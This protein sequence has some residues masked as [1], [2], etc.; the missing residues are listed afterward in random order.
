MPRL[1]LHEATVE[2][3][4]NGR[5]EARP[6]GERSLESMYDPGHFKFGCNDQAQRVQRSQWKPDD[7]DCSR[8][9]E[10]DPLTARFGGLFAD[11]ENPVKFRFIAESIAQTIESALDSVV[12]V[13]PNLQ[14][15]KGADTSSTASSVGRL[16]NPLNIAAIPSL[17]GIIGLFNSINWSSAVATRRFLLTESANWYNLP[18]PTAADDRR[19]RPNHTKPWLTPCLEASGEARVCNPPLHKVGHRRPPCSSDG[20]KYGEVQWGYYPWVRRAAGSLTAV[21]YARDLGI[22]VTAASVH[23]EARVVWV[24]PLPQHCS[25]ECSRALARRP[26]MGQNTSCSPW[27]YLGTQL[28]VNGTHWLGMN[29]ISVS[30][31]ARQ[32]VCPHL[33]SGTQSLDG[34]EANISR[35]RYQ[36]SERVLRDSNIPVVPLE[37]ALSPKWEMHT[38]CTHWVRAN[39]NPH[40][41]GHPTHTQIDSR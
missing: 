38:D 3:L 31:A 23:S 21:D 37:T 41:R 19:A 4:R 33:D 8:L 1:T 12:K 34:C 24:E 16:S 22:L 9:L 28:G 36:V 39:R 13:N 10:L 5:W 2:C 30:P 25:A 40:R 11:P 29:E 26:R 7:P 17:D 27:P 20:C 18:S 14:G 35:W 6:G 32:L 15:L